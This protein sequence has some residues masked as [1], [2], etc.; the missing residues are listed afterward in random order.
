MCVV[1]CAPET[2]YWSQ[3]KWKS[4]QQQCH[5]R[6]THTNRPSNVF[7]TD[8][9]MW[10]SNRHPVTSPSSHPPVIKYDYSEEMCCFCCGLSHMAQK[11]PEQ[12]EEKTWVP[13]KLDASSISLSLVSGLLH[14]ADA[15]TRE[16]PLGLLPNLAMETS[17]TSSLSI[18]KDKY[19]QQISAA[20][21]NI[22]ATKSAVSGVQHSF[23]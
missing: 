17:S 16:F 1:A 23:R 7:I 18:R 3:C 19:N 2:R 14:A 11:I 20:R 13:V 22:W 8:T 5:R 10:S 15:D 4:T 6:E 9:S 12:Q 21:E